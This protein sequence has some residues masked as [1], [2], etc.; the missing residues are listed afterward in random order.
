MVQAIDAETGRTRWMTPV[1][2]MDSPTTKPAVT[3]Q[4]LALING[5]DLYILDAKTGAILEHRRIIGGPGAGPA[6]VGN[7]AFVP[8]MNGRVNAFTFGPKAPWWPSTYHSRGS[9]AF[10]PTTVSGHVAWGNDAG[11]IS[12]IEPGKRGIL[13]RLR[14]T[15]S[16]AGPL[17]ALPPK[18]ILGVTQTG[19]VYSFDIT[20]GRLIWRYSSGN[21]TSE[22]AATVGET[23]F[24][25]TRDHGMHTISAA[26]GERIWPTPY[27]PATKFIAATAERVYCTINTGQIVALDIAT[28]HEVGRIPLSLDDQVFANSQTDRMYIATRSGAIQCLHELGADLPTLHVSDKPE[29]AASET[30]DQGDA[31]TEPADPFAKPAAEAS[32]DAPG[33]DPFEKDAKKVEAKPDADVDPFRGR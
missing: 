20:T 2:S 19:Y 10:Q 1:G 9:V 4:H 13:Y 32:T 7:I 26:T 25:M 31:G 22:P 16:I 14:L 28:G 33:G 24:L 11:D 23:V 30:P 8:L 21:V 17:I 15:D 3:E 18:Q 6:I 5:Q 29:E 12:V 27:A